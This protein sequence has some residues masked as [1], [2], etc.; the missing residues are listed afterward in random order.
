MVD[1]PFLVMNFGVTMATMVISLIFS[2]L[3]LFSELLSQ[4]TTSKSLKSTGIN[5]GL[6]IST[7]GDYSLSPPICCLRTL[8]LR[9]KLLYSF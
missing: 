3:I 5:T 2:T 6:E 1:L 7:D 8:H 9:R 4:T